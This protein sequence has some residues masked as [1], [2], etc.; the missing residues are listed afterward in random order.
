METDV[1]IDNVQLLENFIVQYR[2]KPESMVI[3]MRTLHSI[4]KEPHMEYTLKQL[5]H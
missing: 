1:C 5:T 3:R 4:S 2:L